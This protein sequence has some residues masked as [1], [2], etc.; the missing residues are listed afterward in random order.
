MDLWI[1][2]TLLAAVAQT[3]RFGL[4]RQLKSTRLSST[5]ATFS[6]YLYSA[7]LA[8]AAI[9]FYA[10]MIGQGWPDPTAAYWGYLFLGGSTQILATVC[11]MSLFAR[12]SFSV[13]IAFTKTTVLMAV[14]VG[15]VF[16][17][18]TTSVLGFVAIFVGFVGVLILSD[19]PSDKG[20]GF[21]RRV[22]NAS[23]GLGLAAGLLFAAA[24]VGYRGAVLEMSA[25]DSLFRALFTLAI[26]ATLQ[27]L[28]MAIWMQWREPGEVGRVISN[29]RIAG[30][31]G[32]TSMI[33]STCWFVA[34]STQNVAYV[35]ALGQVELLFSLALT[36]FWFKEKITA[37]EAQG[38]AILMVSILALILV[39]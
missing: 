30:L 25:A 20:V 10:W 39:A 22:L 31:V 24:G 6:R 38:G 36:V 37:R 33:G 19:I 28:A 1:P 26:G 5:G 21:S 32:L 13:G 14:P 34:F 27:T 15:W 2:V 29:W 11:V 7:P 8:V 35:N 12:R 4:Q 18:D 23:T 16:L 17:G 3:L 9:V